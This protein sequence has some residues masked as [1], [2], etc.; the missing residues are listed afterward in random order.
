MS[1]Q[2]AGSFRRW[3]LW[4]IPSIGCVLAM[5]SCGLLAFD[6]RLP[7]DDRIG[8]AR[9]NSGPVVYVL[10]CPTDPI[11]RVRISTM[12][13]EGERTRWEVVSTSSIPQADMV[14]MTI[15]VTPDGFSQTINNPDLDLSAFAVEVEFKGLNHAFASYPRGS[16]PARR[17]LSGNGKVLSPSGFVA[18]AA[19][20]CRDQQPPR[21]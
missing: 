10:N 20:V 4:A 3:A 8:A 9:G 18:Q 19:D 5:A 15:G 16:L 17:I 2:L 21:P 14:E 11:V 13:P 12:T 7:I 1:L 6:D